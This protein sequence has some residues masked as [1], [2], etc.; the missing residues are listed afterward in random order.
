[1]KDCIK[2]INYGLAIAYGGR[3]WARMPLG[4]SRFDVAVRLQRLLFRLEILLYWM[5]NN[6]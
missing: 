4:E 1:M 2:T 3:F 6:F 5:Y